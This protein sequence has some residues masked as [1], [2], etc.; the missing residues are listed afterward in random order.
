VIDGRSRPPITAEN[1]DERRSPVDEARGVDVEQD[2]RV[3]KRRVGNIESVA[4]AISRL[5]ERVR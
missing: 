3:I 5:Q 1:A 2:G 4:H